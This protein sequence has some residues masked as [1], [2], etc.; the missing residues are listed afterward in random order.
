MGRLHADAEDA[1]AGGDHVAGLEPDAVDALVVDEGAIGASQVAE[2]ALGRI[3]LNHEV[4]AGERH[5]LRHRAMHVPRAA[6]DEGV[7]A[8]EDEGSSFLGAFQYIQNHTHRIALGLGEGRTPLPM[9]TV[10]GWRLQT[11]LRNSCREC[12][13]GH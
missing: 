13:S 2:L 7:V 6:D 1:L 9:C 4:I 8:L 12:G 5:V 10:R 3:D 11:L